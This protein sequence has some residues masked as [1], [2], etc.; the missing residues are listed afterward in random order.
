MMWK[1]SADPVADTGASMRAIIGAVLAVAFL[2]G[3]AGGTAQITTAPAPM[4]TDESAIV[5]PDATDAPDAN[6]TP[7]TLPKAYKAPS[8]RE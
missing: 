5:E 6:T 3:C 2:A 7:V 1:L 4:P 8:K